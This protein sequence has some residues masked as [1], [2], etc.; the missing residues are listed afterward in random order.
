MRAPLTPIVSAAASH[1][2]SSG[3]PAAVWVSLG[4]LVFSLLAFGN[5][6]RRDRWLL[7]QKMHE[8]LTTTEQQEN[9]R[10]IHQIAKE[11]RAG[12]PLTDDERARYNNALA[13]LNTMAIYYERHPVSRATLKKF[14]AEPV[15]KLMTVAQPFLKSRD[16]EHLSGR[17]WPELRTFAKAARK[18]GR[19]QGWNL[20]GIDIGEDD[21]VIRPWHGTLA[22]GGQRQ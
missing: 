10:L 12:G 9:R 14:W 8:F 19:S 5:S 4:A 18:Y 6:L 15:L 3:L 13:A 17:I 20:K 2:G 16:A 21:N 11:G 22:G 7:V 1:S